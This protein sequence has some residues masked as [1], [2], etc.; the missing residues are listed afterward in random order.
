MIA[1]GF[2]GYPTTLVLDRQGI[3]RGMWVGYQRGYEQQIEKLV[4][5]L[6]AEK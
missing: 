2:Q 1:D 3:I 5:E 4:A 6:L